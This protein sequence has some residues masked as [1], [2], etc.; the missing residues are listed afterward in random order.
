MNTDITPT[1]ITNEIMNS[2]FQLQE[3]LGEKTFWSF[4]W[5][6]GWGGKRVDELWAISNFRI[7]KM[8]FVDE[9]LI[10]VPLK[11][12]D[13]T[14]TDQHRI[15]VS[16]GIAYGAGL[17]G[18]IALGAAVIERRSTSGSF[19]TLNFVVN[20]AIQLQFFNVADP[21]GVRQLVKV[22]KKQMFG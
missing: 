13:V 17:P 15:S 14:I 5:L 1:D 3:K 19:G 10:Q 9:F 7:I 2:G 12:V 11:H 20:G 8:N 4:K 6:G 22:V 21:A 16:R 18:S